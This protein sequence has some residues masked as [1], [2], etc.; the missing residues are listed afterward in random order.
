M[1]QS[2][3]RNYPRIESDAS[4]DM[5]TADGAVYPAVVLD[6]SLTGAQLLCD[7]P[8]AERVAPRLTATRAED[9]VFLTVR[10]RLKLRDRSTVR[11]QV[12]CQIM[13]VRAVGEDEFRLGLRYESFRDK[14]SYQALEAYVDDWL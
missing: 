6:I 4:A 12:Q 11:L 2:E 8:T 14:G 7:R 10:M 3:K 13:L 1:M 9:C 5:V